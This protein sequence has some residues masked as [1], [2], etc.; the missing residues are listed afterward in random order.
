[1]IL[2][3]IHIPQSEQLLMEAGMVGSFADPLNSLYHLA[4]P[5]PMNGGAAANGLHG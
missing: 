2:S 3:E 4:H 5:S 1:M